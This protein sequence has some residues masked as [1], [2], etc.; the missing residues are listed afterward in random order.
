MIHKFL[1]L[2]AAL[3]V[4]S[5][6]AWAAD[7]PNAKEP[8]SFAQPLLPIFSW[9]G[10]YVGGQV[11]YLWG[12][13]SNY[14]E[15]YP[16]D[17]FLFGGNTLNV[18]G[19]GGGGHLGYNYQISQFVIGIEGDV[20]GTSESGSVLQSNGFT[21][22]GKVPIE[23]SIRGRIGLTWDRTLIYGTGGAEFASIKNTTALGAFSASAN[24]GRIGWT[25]GGGVEY[26]VDPNWTV[27][28]E[29]RYTDY[30]SYDFSF[31]NGDGAHLDATENRVEAGFSY[32]FDLFAPPIPLVAKY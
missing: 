20:E 8:P 22:T 4:M 6:A 15:T 5:G 25:A 3:G 30:G 10:L 19:V 9:T 28:V 2:A 18:R 27:R 11:G 16:A 14:V 32:K 24:I 31:G 23:A 12:G 7:L 29:Y 21:G 1:V 17:V 13:A 26:A